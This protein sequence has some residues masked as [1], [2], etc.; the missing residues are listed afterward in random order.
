MVAPFRRVE[1]VRT[2]DE[3]AQLRSKSSERSG[4]LLSLRFLKL[5]EGAFET[6]TA[7][8]R[9]CPS[10]DTSASAADGCV[11][12]PRLTCCCHMGP[13][14]SAGLSQFH[15]SDVS[16]R[17]LSD[18]RSQPGRAVPREGCSHDDQAPRC[19]RNA[20]IRRD[21]QERKGC[22]A[23]KCPRLLGLTSASCCP[24]SHRQHVTL[25]VRSVR[26]QP[27]PHCS[28]MPI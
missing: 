17:L 26:P 18:P 5:G 11:L 1:V 24:L 10:D 27:R 21:S 9:R 12:P 8:G 4:W 23:C 25:T 14:C 3:Q 16:E 7:G 22:T 2:A 20:H 28:A 13:N 15:R 6:T 19:G